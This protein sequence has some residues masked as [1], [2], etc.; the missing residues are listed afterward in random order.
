[1]PKS[2]GTFTGSVN[3]SSGTLTVPTINDN[4]NINAAA[5][6]EYVDNKVNDILGATDAMVFKGTLDSLHD[7]PS[8][9]DGYS[10]GWT[11][12]VNQAGTYAD[13]PCEIGD[14]VIAINDA[15]ST[16]SEINPN[17]WTVVQTNTDGAIYKG[18]N[19]LV[20]G[21]II[22]A[23]GTNGQIRDSGVSIPDNPDLTNTTY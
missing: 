6:K 8:P 20:S 22:I 10:A 3:F 5:T 13:K 7:L 17:D 1:M 12:R 16:A 19:T 9:S 21:N 2:G 23:D 15:S 18:S 11:Y 4:S 14:L